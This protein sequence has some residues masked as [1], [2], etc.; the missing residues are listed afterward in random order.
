MPMPKGMDR[1][2]PPFVHAEPG[3]TR[4][5]MRASDKVG[6]GRWPLWS[7][8]LWC[9]DRLPWDHEAA[10]NT[11]LILERGI[12]SLAFLEIKNLHVA[13]E[14]GTEI[15]KGSTSTST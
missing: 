5:R 14:D 6:W 11:A 7:Y 1:T 3:R 12:T 15:V 13:L 2:V 4:G 10:R 8:P 9:P